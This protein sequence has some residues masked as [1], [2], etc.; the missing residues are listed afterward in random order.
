MLAAYFWSFVQGLRA[1]TKFSGINDAMFSN[2]YLSVGVA[3]LLLLAGLHSVSSA[4]WYVA[5]LL[6]RRPLGTPVSYH[7]TIWP[8][9]LLEA[10]ST[11]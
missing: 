7:D 3:P 5:D 11:R 9:G 1:L 6:R 2:V 4:S 8:A 10:F